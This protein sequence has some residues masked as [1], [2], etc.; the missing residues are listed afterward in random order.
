MK[1]HMM[2]KEKRRYQRITPRKKAFALIDGAFSGTCKIHDISMKGIGLG[3]ISDNVKHRLD[4]EVSLF[5]PKKGLRVT[6]LPCRILYQ[7]AAP[8]PSPELTDE[9]LFERFRYGIAFDKLEK[10]HRKILSK[11][12][13]E[14]ET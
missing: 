14:L 12:I 13:K 11:F 9:A 3:S 5:I 10:S 1:E 6:S 2:Q 7:L 4:S 8:N